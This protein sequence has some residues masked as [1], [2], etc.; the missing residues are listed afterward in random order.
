MA[1]SAELQRRE[2]K[3]PRI[4]VLLFDGVKMLDFVGPAEVFHEASQ[5]TAGYEIVPI[6]V[7]GKDVVSSMGITVGVQAAAA[8][9]DALDTLIIPGTEQAPEVFLDEGLLAAVSELAARSRRVASIC[10]A[11]F[12]LAAVGLLDGRTTTTHW[13]FAPTL[14][15]TFPSVTVKADAIFVHDGKY[16][17]SAGVAAGIDLA[18][19][20][21]EDD[22]GAD[23]A[24]SVAQLLLVYMKRSGSQSQFSASL[25]GKPPRSSVAKTVTD[26]IHDD[27]TRAYTVD[28]LAHYAGVS[29][30][31]LARVMRD[32][33][34]LSPAE[35]VST[36]RLD[37]AVARL[38]AGASVAETA[39]ATGYVS[40]VSLRRAFVGRFG[41]TPSEY[42][43]RF[44]TSRATVSP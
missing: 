22:Y 40:P 15:A 13:K 5:R 35:Y 29:P 24:R 38:E 42:Q 43:R 16:H 31:H 39:S 36:I 7:D 1:S 14:A 4:G 2:T 19:A 6:S 25:R 44:Q 32:E 37:L 33:L 41:I 21:L 26:R 9:I 27:P 3:P 28:E 12:A 11:A 18:L 23:A 8:D 17:S 30:R 34:G 10:T 20:L